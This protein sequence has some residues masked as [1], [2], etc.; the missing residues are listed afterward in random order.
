MPGDS[1]RTQA[2]PTMPTMPPDTAPRI[3]AHVRVR[4][5]VQGVGF[6]PHV[7]RLAGTYALD[8]WVLN[9][10]D[11]LHIHVEGA[12]DSIA[13]FLQDL[14]TTPPPAARIT[15]LEFVSCAPERERPGFEILTSASE[16]RPTTRISPDLPICDD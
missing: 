8:G 12:P 6:R 1:E 10:T 7:Y 9:R 14:A 4:G 5:V 11:G 3:A 13:S 16:R 15:S 2:M